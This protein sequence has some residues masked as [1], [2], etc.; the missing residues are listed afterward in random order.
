MKLS[1]VK[2]G[3]DPDSQE[4]WDLFFL[5]TFNS[6]WVRILRIYSQRLMF[7]FAVDNQE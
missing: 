2:L 4:Q 3:I 6:A 7:D 5:A 1:N